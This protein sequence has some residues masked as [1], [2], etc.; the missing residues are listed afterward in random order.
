MLCVLKV[1]S[2][3]IIFS[4]FLF[5]FIW[6]TAF[7]YGGETKLNLKVFKQ[8]YRINPEKWSYRESWDDEI[9]H[10]RYS[11]YK[12]KLTFFAFCWF[13]LNRISSRYKR[14]KEEERNNLIWILEDCQD[15]INYLKRQADK[16]IEKALKIQK[17]IFNN[18]R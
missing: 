2:I 17:K 16:D 14:N 3:I 4:L 11:D 10:L 15:D 7:N 18:W 5:L 8:I 1:F 6:K 13:L 12:V 9:R